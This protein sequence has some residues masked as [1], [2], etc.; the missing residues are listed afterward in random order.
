MY[1]TGKLHQGKLIHILKVG[2]DFNASILCKDPEERFF[3]PGAQPFPVNNTTVD[4]T[5]CLK[6]YYELTEGK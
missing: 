1:T 4:C 5:K 3:S 6:K 2:E